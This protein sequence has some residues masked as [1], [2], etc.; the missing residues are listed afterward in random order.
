MSK[1]HCIYQTGLSPAHAAL[2]EE[3]FRFQPRRPAPRHP[4]M[5]CF[6]HRRKHTRP[7]VV[8]ELARKGSNSKLCFCI[9]QKPYRSGDCQGRRASWADPL[10]TVWPA[11]SQSG[12]SVTLPGWPRPGR[13]DRRIDQAEPV[14]RYQGRAA[15]EAD[16]QI[17]ARAPAPGR[18]ARPSWRLSLQA[19]RPG[20]VPRV[21]PS[22]RDRRRLELLPRG[23]LARDGGGR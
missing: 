10:L 1:E 16:I 23:W 22:R 15:G 13:H 12:H 2:S 8:T 18:D 6:H 20:R 9:L 4:A 7:R 11:R 3:T 14:E 5:P 17:D 21:P 19:R